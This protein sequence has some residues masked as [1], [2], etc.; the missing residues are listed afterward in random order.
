MASSMLSEFQSMQGVVVQTWIWYF[1]IG[2]W[3]FFFHTDLLQTTIGDKAICRLHPTFLGPLLMELSGHTSA[4][5]KKRKQAENTQGPGQ[6]QGVEVAHQMER[7]TGNLS[8]WDQSPG[9]SPPLTTAC[10]RCYSQWGGEKHNSES[11]IR[12][13]KTTDHGVVT[14]IKEWWVWISIMFLNAMKWPISIF[15]ESSYS[16]EATMCNWY[17]F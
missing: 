14:V 11:K 5:S 15:K 17:F 13:R 1:T 3:F 10:G 7:A 8:M 6:Q 12:Q 9:P 2:F 4:M 16:I